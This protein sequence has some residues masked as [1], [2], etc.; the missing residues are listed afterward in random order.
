MKQG[1]KEGTVRGE[2]KKYTDVEIIEV[3]SKYETIKD[4]RASDDKPFYT[5]ALRRGLKK[6]LPVKRTKAMN[7]V[8]SALEKK[9]LAKEEK[10]LQV[11]KVKGKPGRLKIEKPEKIEKVDHNKPIRAIQ[12]YKH[13]FIDGY[14]VC[15]RCFQNEPKTP[16][17]T[18]CKD[19]NKVY[20]RKH[21]YEQDHVPYNLKQDFCNTTIQHHEKT[22]EIGIRVD[23]KLQ[24]Y[25]TLVGYGFLFQE[26]WENIWK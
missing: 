4:L 12:I 7:I 23:E 24:N 18:L 20:A 25:L 6:Y 9:L 16:N 11:P 26:P 1:V 10:L 3:I 5:L 8:G 21:A 19:C 17:S 13:T 2:Y 22:F 15:G 14:K